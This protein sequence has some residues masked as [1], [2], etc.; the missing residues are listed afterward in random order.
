VFSYIPF[1]KDPQI[2]FD[3]SYFFYYLCILNLNKMAA[4]SKHHGDVAIWIEKVINSCET[5]LQEVAARK[6][7]RLFETQYFNID[8][9]LGWSLSRK[10]RAA[11][12]NKLYSRLHKSQETFSN[13]E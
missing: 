6:L 5:P 8:Q 11:L 1:P 4:T 3:G 13:P 2:Y 7:V 12:D 9:E 10:L